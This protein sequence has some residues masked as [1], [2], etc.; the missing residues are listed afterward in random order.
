M[1]GTANAP[2]ARPVDVLVVEDGNEYLTNLTTFVAE[3]F[4]YRQAKSGLEAQ[5]MLAERRPDLVYLD[6]RFDRTPEEELLGNLVELSARFNGDTAR[7]RRFQQD[8]Q[9]LFVLRALR[10]ANYAGP[11]ILSYDFGPEE[12]RFKALS[13]RDPFLRYCPDYADA[14]SI[15][16]A[17]LEAVGA[18]AG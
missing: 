16:R 12:R 6:M 14:A 17:I 8:N 15:R 13:A 5:R 3:G 7:A 4:A 9:G 10:E 18:A 1:S 11:V 2:G